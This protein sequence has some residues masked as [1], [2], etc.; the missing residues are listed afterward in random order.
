MGP[1]VRMLAGILIFTIAF[2]S[3]STSQH[4]ESPTGR[5]GFRFEPVSDSSLGLW[6]G[7]KRVLVYNHGITPKPALEGAKE[8]STYIHPIYGLDGEVLTDDY[9]KDHV[10]HRGL[11][12]AWPHITIEDNEY[13]LWSLSG[14]RLE[15]LRWVKKEGKRDSATL[16]AV[17]G[18]F[19]LDR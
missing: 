9:P 3:G 10:H 5:K 8:R 7:D 2:A 6:E 13:D 1:F 17:N 14:I 15:F 4:T 18:W 12:W 11:Y 16:S 19:V